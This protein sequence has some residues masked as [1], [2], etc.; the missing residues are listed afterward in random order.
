MGQRGAAVEGA[1][2]SDR[3]AFVTGGSGAIGGAV[4]DR[5]AAAGSA[6]AVGF[7]SDEAGAA[8]TVDAITGAGGTAIAVAVDVTDDDSVEAAFAAV[9]ADL[10][11]VT[12]LVNN[13]GRTADGLLVRMDRESWDDVLAVNLT[14][15]FSMTRRAVRSMMRAREG[16]IVNIGSVVASVGSP[17]QAN[18]AA[19]KAGLVGLTRSTARELATR[20]ITCNL[21]E[22]GP[23]DT[24]MTRALSEERREVLRGEV[25]AGRFGTPAE[26]AHAVGF[27]CSPEAGFVTGAVV[28]V[29][30]GLAMG[31]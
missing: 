20:G 28:P 9:E 11:P 1:V 5:L 17:G 23:I 15:A 16:R 13:A 26:V 10:G 27:L 24:A 12:I 18:Y 30:G 8:G 7:S 25:P 6:V 4:A 3:V 22:P 2:V 21:V 19:A 14:G 29:D 31:R